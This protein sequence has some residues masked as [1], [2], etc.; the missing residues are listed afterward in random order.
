MESDVS[1]TRSRI[2]RA[3]KSKNT[4]PELAVRRL[5]HSMGYRYRLHDR[6]LP[7]RPDIVFPGLKKVVFVNG[8]FWH[9]HE[10]CKRFSIPKTRSDW[11]TRKL[12]ANAERDLRNIESLRKLGWDSKVVWECQTPDANNLRNDLNEFLGK[13]S[14]FC[15]PS[16]PNSGIPKKENSIPL[17]E[18]IVSVPLGAKGGL[19]AK[20]KKSKSAAKKSAAKSSSASSKAAKASKK[21][22]AAKRSIR[23][24]K[25]KRTAH[26]SP[27][28]ESGRS[29]PSK[30]SSQTD[31]DAGTMKISE[32][33]REI[34]IHMKSFASVANALAH[35]E[36][37]TKGKKST[38]PKIT[39]S[40]GGEPGFAIPAEAM[41]DVANAVSVFG[42]ALRTAQPQPI[43]VVVATPPPQAEPQVTAPKATKATVQG[44]KSS[45]RA[46][47][48]EETIPEWFKKGFKDEYEADRDGFWLK[49]AQLSIH[50]AKPKIVLGLWKSGDAIS[51]WGYEVLSGT[52]HVAWVIADDPQR[53][54]IAEEEGV[55]PSSHRAIIGVMARIASMIMPE[56]R[57][58]G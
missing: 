4:T 8:C 7:G 49:R 39:V 35:M 27:Q 52:E 45:K 14:Q 24:V 17:D 1:E 48:S 31:A 33:K 57:N 12:Y 19:M 13:R 23:S 16:S 20:A 41:S 46:R 25:A 44:R 40:F 2:M 26:R 55:P 32:G 6:K 38:P 47:P 43:K 29:L 54:L 30:Y 9:A 28:T 42:L 58:R 15:L 34:T 37:A 18:N 5:V 21:K 53:F 36:M 51:A 11:W 56:F 10:G 22:T 50:P 3:V